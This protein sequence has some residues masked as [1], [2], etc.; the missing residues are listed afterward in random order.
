M[1]L[2][3]PK[4]W[5]PT[6]QQLLNKRSI[7]VDGVR[8][9]IEQDV[10]ANQNGEINTNRGRP[11]VGEVGKVLWPGAVFLIEYLHFI[12]RD[13][14]NV[15]VLELGCGPGLVGVYLGLLGARCV[16]TDLDSI[17]ALTQR[18]VDLNFIQNETSGEAC[19]PTV[20]GY[21][22]NSD[23]DSLPT[24][25]RDGNFDFI[26]ASEVLYEQCNFESLLQ[27]MDKHSTEMTRIFISYQ[28][29]TGREFEYCKQK[30]STMGFSVGLVGTDD[31]PL[32]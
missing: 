1:S 16:M 18:N 4:K 28:I 31:L 22:W 6:Q 15:E 17:I 24:P 19:A 25:L 5:S 2:Q 27:V 14:Q 26:V 7:I 30:F 10:V 9:F 29:R 32:R 13:W 11:D 23:K 12:L 20:I 3:K 21:D 8:V